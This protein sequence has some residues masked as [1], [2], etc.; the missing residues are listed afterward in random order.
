MEDEA[1]EAAVN[2]FTGL[3]EK[4]GGELVKVDKWGKRRLAYPI[5]KRNEG[6]Y[7]LVNFKAEPAVSHEVERVL[8]ITD[9]VIRHMVIVQEDK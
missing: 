8:R 9:E 2:K 6:Y 1:T 7:V 3:I 4:N 5:N